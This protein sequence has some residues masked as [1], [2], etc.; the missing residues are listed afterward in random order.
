MRKQDKNRTKKST[1]IL[2]SAEGMGVSPP[3]APRCPGWTA[4][5]KMSFDL[6]NAEINTN[7][8]LYYSTISEQTNQLHL[9]THT[10]TVNR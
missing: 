7:M 4:R 10:Q 5:S 6:Q 3:K 2:Y 9:Y 8:Q 1:L